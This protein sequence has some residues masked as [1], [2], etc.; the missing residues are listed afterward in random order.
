[1]TPKGGLDEQSH[2]IF[3]TLKGGL[4]EQS[5]FIYISYARRSG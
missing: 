1:M 5:R 2:F 4:D 3:I